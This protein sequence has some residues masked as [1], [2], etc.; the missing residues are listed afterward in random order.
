MVWRIRRCG[1]TWDTTA[2]LLV[3]GTRVPRGRTVGSSSRSCRPRSRYSLVASTDASTSHRGSRA[4]D[5]CSFLPTV[6]GSCSGD[7]ARSLWFGACVEAG[8]ATFVARVGGRSD[9]VSRICPRELVAVSFC[10][11]RP[12]SG[13]SLFEI[14]YRSSGGTRGQ[15]RKPV[16]P[17]VRSYECCSVFLA[18]RVSVGSSV[19]VCDLARQGHGYRKRAIRHD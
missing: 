8:V 13:P 7:G 3:S 17:Q 9:S 5:I 6:N 12:V 18:L 16:R 15:Q 14:Q 1:H 2:F 4:S 19:S 10:F 11:R